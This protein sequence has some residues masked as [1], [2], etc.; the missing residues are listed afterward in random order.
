MIMSERKL[1]TMLEG[2][3]SFGKSRASKGHWTSKGHW[4]DDNHFITTMRGKGDG[5]CQ[6]KSQETWDIDQFKHCFQSKSGEN[7][8]E[9]ILTRIR[10]ENYPKLNKTV[11]QE[12]SLMRSSL[13]QKPVRKEK[14][15][16][17]SQTCC[18]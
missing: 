18:L 15:W 13:I 4:G 12:E 3:Q 7:G 14:P 9:G 8:Q 10:E 6:R 11:L 2:G 16:A 1:S 17:P 5:K